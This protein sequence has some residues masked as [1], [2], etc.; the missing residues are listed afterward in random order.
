[1][2]IEILH[3]EDCPNWRDAVERVT[4]VLIELGAERTPVRATLL[5]S[6]AEAATVA[7]AGSPTILIDGADAF[8]S[9][10]RT[11]DLACRVYPVDGRFAGI[12]SLADLR[13]VISTA[14]LR[15]E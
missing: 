14:L 4:D 6:P 12:P 11:S 3:I 9:S 10:G 15:S 13:T 1:M 8:P 5:A 7:F 2:E